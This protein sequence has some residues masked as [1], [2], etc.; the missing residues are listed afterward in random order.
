MLG[1]IIFLS[2]VAFIPQYVFL[3]GPLYYFAFSRNNSL[4]NKN[5]FSFN[6]NILIIGSIILLSFINILSGTNPKTS[7]TDFFPYTTLMFLSY[8]FAFAVKRIDLKIIIYLI[9]LESIVVITQHFMGVTTFFSELSVETEASSI[10]DEDLLYNNR[11]LGLSSNSSI[12][13][14]KFLLAFILI[15]FLQLRGKLYTALKLIIFAGV[16]YTFNRTVLLV[17]GIYIF[18]SI[19]KKSIYI[20]VDLMDLKIKQ[21]NF[22]ITIIGSILLFSVVVFS[23]QYMDEIVV[24]LTRDKGVDM[25]GRDL[26]W[27]NFLSFIKEN[28]MFGHHSSKY[29]FAEYYSGP[30]H[31]H[32]SFLQ[33]I[34]NHGIII[35]LLFILLIIVNL[36]RKNILLVFTLVFYS[37]FQYG[38]FWGISITDIILF[39]ALFRSAED[40]TTQHPVH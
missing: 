30:I 19:S 32:N 6:V 26:I 7:Y 29:Y 37:V 23:I 17:L 31:A 22:L 36:S 38:V 1:L 24:Q 39:I 12:A 34:A 40:F 14:L 2:T 35:S 10:I 13:A 28:L 16:F 11:A 33:I 21:S 4:I 18:F 15:D 20:L 8:F 25:S 3:L 9:V 5:M 27:A